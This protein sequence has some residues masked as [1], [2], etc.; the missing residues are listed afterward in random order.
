MPSF[1]E[2]EKRRQD[3]AADAEK[4]RI[5]NENANKLATEA[6]KKKEN[7]N[8]LANQVKEDELLYDNVKLI[9]DGRQ[10]ATLKRFWNCNTWGVLLLHKVGTG[11]TIT[12]LLIAL[13]TFRKQQKQSS[14]SNPLEIIVIAPIGI[15]A[16]FQ[17][18]LCSHI[19][20]FDNDENREKFK[21]NLTDETVY[22]FFDIHFKLVNYNFDKLIYDLN[23]K[24]Y[25]QFVDN[26][27]IIF[28]EAHRLLTNDI[29]NSTEAGGI[30]KKHAII[31]DVN[32]KESISNALRV[33]TMSGTP[34]QQ[35]PADLC[36]FGNF[37]TK[38]HEFTSNKYAAKIADLVWVTF[39]I[40]QIDVIK[41]TFGILS[42]LG[43]SFLVSKARELPNYSLSTM[44][45]IL[46]TSLA[47]GALS[48]GLNALTVN[49]VK[50]EADVRL[51]R[52]GFGGGNNQIKQHG[53]NEAIIAQL[54]SIFFATINNVIATAPGSI[55]DSTSQ[56]MLVYGPF[57]AETKDVL[58]VINEP[59]FNIELL[60]KS[61]SPIISIYDYEIQDRINLACI[62]K[63]D[64][65]LN[66]V[67]NKDGVKY[68]ELKK[69]GQEFTREQSIKSLKMIH[70]LKQITNVDEVLKN[71]PNCNV[72]PN[73]SLDDKI[74]TRFPD[75]HTS[76]Q[77]C[78]FD[79]IQKEFIKKFC[80]DTLTDEE[81]AI[82]YLNKYESKNIDYKE[83]LKYFVHNFKFI[84][85]YSLD[86]NN[87]YSTLGN[88]AEKYYY[89][90]Y[91]TV[92]DQPEQKVG[93]FK[94]SK[95]ERAL[96]LLLQIKTGKMPIVNET[97]ETTYLQ[98]PHGEN[99]MF[100]LP[101]VYSYNEDFG[102]GLFAN[103]LSSMG[104]KYILINKLQE[105]KTLEKNKKLAFNTMYGQKYIQRE[106]PICVLIDPT[107]TEGLNATYN[108]CILI[109]EACNSFGDSEQVEGRV[110]RKYGLP[111]PEKKI[112]VIY[113]FLTQL[114]STD[115][116][117]SLIAQS[118]NRLIKK[119]EVL[120]DTL[121]VQKNQN[122]LLSFTLQEY[123][124]AA[125]SFVFISPDT[126]FYEKIK[127]EKQNLTNFEKQIRGG[128]ATSDIKEANECIKPGSF[129]NESV[130]NF[131]E[132]KI[133]L[134]SNSP[135]PEEAMYIDFKSAREKQD[136]NQFYDKLNGLSEAD[137]LKLSSELKQFI[138]S[139]Q[140]N[141]KDCIIEAKNIYDNFVKGLNQS[142]LEKI[143]QKYDNMRVRNYI[144]ST[145]LLSNPDSIFCYLTNKA[146][147][148]SCDSGRLKKDLWRNP[149]F[150][151][152][153][154]DL[155]MNYLNSLL[156]EQPP[157]N[158]QP[159]NTSSSNSSYQ[160]PFGFGIL[161]SVTQGMT[162]VAKN[163]WMGGNKKTRRRNN[164]KK[165]RRKRS[166]NTRKSV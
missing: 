132:L 89:K 118:L 114:T 18:D 40:K 9:L 100:Y 131:D 101:V 1:Q 44:G 84:S 90:K 69:Q 57:K 81:K 53:G 150:Y 76:I 105:S 23:S 139:L 99:N 55:I 34:M 117:E 130:N 97:N 125:A 49:Y 32:F 164:N 98:H 91:P 65:V 80:L 129:N 137:N 11:K 112:K 66:F 14:E 157:A 160:G 20:Y 27:I 121:K 37:L 102:L 31:D 135:I 6:I 115:T 60:A 64:Y 142:Q 67:L 56:E 111:F 136:Y 162:R 145:T 50:K 33:I 71:A 124:T 163:A 154:K 43:Y 29:F 109:L 149:I 158:T 17:N 7:L 127:R 141:F 5:E 103:Y 3:K 47:I 19:L 95:Y 61:L 30:M 155:F 35:S 108:P 113:Q 147:I 46:L 45:P 36:K 138:D 166:N 156:G 22:K 152:L 12:S 77:M 106:D 41:S 120:T 63:I 51:K 15:Y 38:S 52:H 94:C 153:Q 21:Q 16:G 78:F 88:G 24:K 2:R 165:T 68:N 42:S 8:E 143:K 92:K 148:K 107:M 74:D 26:Q 79:E 161:P 4:Q 119:I 86:L 87:Y 122:N 134:F 39:M 128:P 62:D 25:T 110:L 48:T 159:A 126:F 59:V 58:N 133:Q 116:Q 146:D 144:T 93:V 151:E 28:D 140:N 82:F 83:K 73:A 10:E 85:N 75:K 96:K 104:H 72:D 13:N 70:G 123:W 54:N